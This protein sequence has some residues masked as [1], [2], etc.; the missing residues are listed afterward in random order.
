MTLSND[1]LI[2]QIKTLFSNPIK[3]LGGEDNVDI[4]V[5]TY[6]DANGK[7][8]HYRARIKNP[9]TGKKEI[10]PFYFDGSRWQP[11]EPTYPDKKPLYNLDLLATADE[12]WLVEGE[13]KADKAIEM[14]KIA[15]TTGGARGLDKYDFEPLRGKKI[16]LWPDN[17]DAGQDWL[18]HAL[19]YANTWRDFKVV[20]VSRLDLLPKG[21][22][23]DYV[24]GLNYKDLEVAFDD[25][26]MLATEAITDL[27][28]PTTTTDESKDSIW[29]DLPPR[30]R[31]NN[32]LHP[33]LP[34][35]LQFLENIAEARGLDVG[36]V[37]NVF[38]GVLGGLTSVF[39]KATYETQTG[40]EIKRD[41]SP[42]NQFTLAALGVGGGKTQFLE[43]LKQPLI[44][45]YKEQCTR[46]DSLK[47][48]DCKE[49]SKEQEEIWLLENPYP[50][51]PWNEISGF[52]PQGLM[53]DK[54]GEQNL[55]KLNLVSDEARSIIKG[56]SA[57]A[58]QDT[59][60]FMS[61]IANAYDGKIKSYHTR[62]TNTNQKVGLVP[63]NLCLLGQP[64]VLDT[65]L[66]EPIYA[67]TGCS[68]RF[69]IFSSLPRKLVH[70]DS[71]MSEDTQL[72]K[73]Q[74]YDVMTVFLN[75]TEKLPTQI[76]YTEKARKQF[77]ELKYYIQTDNQ[78]KARHAETTERIDAIAM[79]LFSMLYIWDKASTINPNEAIFKQ[80]EKSDNTAPVI[81]KPTIIEDLW[82]HNTGELWLFIQDFMGWYIQHIKYLTDKSTDDP[83]LFKV[84]DFLHAQGAQQEPVKRSDIYRKKVI[85][86]PHD[87]NVT[88]PAT[89]YAEILDALADLGYVKL[90]KEGKKIL[91]KLH[92]DYT[93]Y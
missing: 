72:Y 90:I 48:E 58:G 91:V 38:I 31:S 9:R 34:H 53:Q 49:Q 35:N 41:Y 74:Y 6:R 30:D 16:I 42:I 84:L 1:E 73:N 66:N 12:V 23:V 47:K 71:L 59:N 55:Y 21:D 4:S 87:N 92:P 3:S 85:R 64:D 28:T 43:L 81:K 26:P 8:L 32:H 80:D 18:V 52:T 60:F 83:R 54:S 86:N 88:A 75:H 56:E 19:Q 82:E 77:A 27:V 2:K 69:L 17:D 65:F 57:G 11:K 46:W 78:L 13:N 14:G 51:F 93:P 50:S 67:E 89:T 70:P 61:F 76:V 24:D 5:H 44:A 63:F 36:F 62:Q 45:Y 29:G 37:F 33:K 7:P 79:R 20:D 68:S 22:L 15:T 10:R 39:A 40:S 25:L